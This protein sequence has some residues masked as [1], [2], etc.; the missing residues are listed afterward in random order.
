MDLDGPLLLR[1]GEK[2]YG[3][4]AR[5]IGRKSKLAMEGGASKVV[6]EGFK[7]V[8]TEEKDQ[9]LT[10]YFLEASDR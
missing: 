8:L 2:Q 5:T 6:N 7:P 10:S 9:E 3:V 1:E 4:P